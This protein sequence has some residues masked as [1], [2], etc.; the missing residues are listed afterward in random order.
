MTLRRPGIRIPNL[1]E[2]D[3]ARAGFRTVLAQLREEMKDEPEAEFDAAIEEAF[4]DLR[5]GTR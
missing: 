4:Q 5:S 2:R 1:Q 3:V